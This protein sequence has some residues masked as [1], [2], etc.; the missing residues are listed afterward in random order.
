MTTAT[1]AYVRCET[2]GE[3]DHDP[4]YGQCAGCAAERTQGRERCACKRRTVKPG[5]DH[6]YLCRQEA[7]GRTP[8]ARGCGRFANP[9][10]RVCWQCEHGEPPPGQAWSLAD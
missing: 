8:C 2:C 5:H 1:L 10:F 3:R 7:A 4:A 6:C 9:G